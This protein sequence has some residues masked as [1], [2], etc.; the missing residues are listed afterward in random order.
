MRH[1]L[2]LAARGEREIVMTRAF[3]APRELVF[4]AYTRP[5]LLKRWLGVF[6]GWTLET[7]EVDLR[8]GGRYR[9][10]WRVPGGKQM[11]MGGLFREIVAPERLVT[12]ERFDDP[13]Y[14]G[15][16]VSTLLLEDRD[17]GTLMTNVVT[18]QSRAVRDG[19]LASPME[20]GLV[21]SYDNLEQV[22]AESTTGPRS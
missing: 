22:L 5:D 16:A 10:V 7:C 9:Y 8:V 6:N 20:T 1:A 3:D 14:E 13:W 21:A 18:Y 12:T 17:G 4:E 19:V 11:G 2:Q 15:E